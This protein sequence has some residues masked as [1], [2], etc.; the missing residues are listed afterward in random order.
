MAKDSYAR[1]Q[2]STKAELHAML[3]EAV[4]QY[5][6]P[7]GTRACP[8]RATRAEAQNATPQ[9]TTT[10]AEAHGQNQKSSPLGR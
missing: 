4:P 10:C 3:A 1:P 2:K 6:T 9:H 7:A 5:T 8:R